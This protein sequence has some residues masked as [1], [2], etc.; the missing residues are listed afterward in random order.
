M[1]PAAAVAAHAAVSGRGRGGIRGGRARVVGSADALRAAE[2]SCRAALRAGG[3]APGGGAA[4]GDRTAAYSAGAGTGTGG[5]D[6]PAARSSAS[7]SAEPAGVASARLVQA[8]G[9]RRGAAPDRGRRACTAGAGRHA[10]VDPRAVRTR[11]DAAAQRLLQRGAR[12]VRRSAH[13]DRVLG[14]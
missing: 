8:A 1:S 11:G 6:R 9:I 14:R 3:V 13:A 10:R 7:R 12:D 4:R 2:R 5:V